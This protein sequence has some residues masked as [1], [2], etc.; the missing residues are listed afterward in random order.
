MKKLLCLILSFT[1]AFGL[2]ACSADEEKTPATEIKAPTTEAT[3]TASAQTAELLVGFGRE[4]IMP[5][6]NITLGGSGTHDRVSE[7]YLDFLYTTCIAI[8]DGEDNTVLLVTNDLLNARKEYSDPAKERISQATGI[9]VENIMMAGTHTH[10]APAMGNSRIDGAAAYLEVV[11]T[12]CTKA[13]QVAMQDRAPAQILAGKA[14]AT[15]LAFSRHYTLNDGTVKKDLTSADIPVGHPDEPD[16]DVQIVKFDRGEEKKPVI[17]MTFGV[18]PTF[19][20]QATKK[21]ISADFPGPTRDYIESQTGALVAY[22]TSAAGNQVGDSKVQSERHGMEY[23]DYGKA[24]GQVV[25]DALPGLTALEAGPVKLLHQEFVGTSNKDKVEQ[26]A[27]ANLVQDEYEK[28]GEKYLKPMLQEYGF[29]SV[30]EANA[31]IDRAK[32]ADTQNVPLN[33]L[34]IGELS[35]IFAPYEMFGPTAE[36]IKANTPYG[37]TLIVTCA[38]GSMGYLPTDK[39]YDYHVYEGFVTKFVRGT[40]ED[41]ADTFLSMLTQLQG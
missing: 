2:L 12:G 3:T 19:N 37:M 9:S 31:I 22:F 8:T 13:A 30:W 14:D 24:L 34:S 36:Y 25:I 10:A 16:D 28:N 29:D 39:A 5:N 32:L 40:A 6:G 23:K 27:E 7:G 41:L 11:L 20:G 4:K 33:A 21:M 1:L 26:L 38:N 35:M 17:M 15:G 18:H